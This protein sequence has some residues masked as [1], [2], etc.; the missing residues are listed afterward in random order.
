MNVT[1]GTTSESV[2]MS[3]PLPQWQNRLRVERG[4]QKG[5]ILNGVKP[6]SRRLNRRGGSGSSKLALVGARG[7][8][9]PTPA[10]RTQCATGLRY[11][12]T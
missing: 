4:Y 11:A 1:E 8:E 10:S 5:I 6:L 12:P 3:F 2:G 9:P 7:F